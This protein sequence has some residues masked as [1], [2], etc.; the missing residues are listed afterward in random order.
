MFFLPTF[1]PPHFPICTIFLWAFSENKTD[2]QKNP[3][4]R[5]FESTNHFSCS[6]VSHLF[7]IGAKNLVF[8]VA[9]VSTTPR[10][11]DQFGIAP[12]R[13]F[14]T[15]HLEGNISPPSAFP[16]SVLY[17]EQPFPFF[18]AHP[19][20]RDCRQRLVHMPNHPFFVLSS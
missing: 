14:F 20:K 17:P 16:L 18:A 8:F 9:E 12:I 3:L 11:I 1:F 2:Q 7:P 10:P 15:T 4:R 13:V 6:I 19:P 5:Y